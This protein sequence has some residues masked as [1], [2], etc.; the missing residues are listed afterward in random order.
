[1]HYLSEPGLIT[2]S[3]LWCIF[4]N[5]LVE[6]KLPES[7]PIKNTACSWSI[8]VFM[9]ILYCLDLFLNSRTSFI[10]PTCAFLFS[11]C[12]LFFKLFFCSSM[13][14]LVAYYHDSLYKSC[15]WFIYSC[16]IIY[17]PET[18]N[19]VRHS[20]K[21]GPS[22]KIHKNFPSSPHTFNFPPTTFLL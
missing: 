20:V 16:D 2:F 11:I 12:V 8:K 22:K 1:M 4:F 18:V 7:N 5:R 19:T 6:V 17:Q 13:S 21:Q 14:L 15:A 3:Y 10:N 9:Q